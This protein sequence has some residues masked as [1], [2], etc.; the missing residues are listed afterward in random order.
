MLG[1]IEHLLEEHAA[2][3]RVLT[4]AQSALDPFE[5]ERLETALK[6]LE[7]IMDRVHHAKEEDALFPMLAECTDDFEPQTLRAMQQQHN[8]GRSYLRAAKALLEDAREGSA[9][10]LSALAETV[11]A[12]DRFTRTHMKQ[13]E[14]VLFPMIANVLSPERDEALLVH[15]RRVQGLLID[16]GDY[17]AYLDL[18]NQLDHEDRE[19]QTVITRPPDPEPIEPERSAPRATHVM[20][21]DQGHCVVRIP[22]LASPSA[23][24][25]NVY[26]VRDH[27]EAILLDPGGPASYPRI[28]DEVVI[29]LEDAR[30]EYV[31]LSHQDPDVGASVRGWL[32][33]TDAKV[34]SP[35]A[36]VRFIAHYGLD[37]IVESRAV[38]VPDEG[39]ILA[40]GSSD[41][42]VLPAHFLHSS[43]NVQLFD[44]RSKI[45]FSGDLGA[46]MTSASVV[47]DFDAHV[48]ELLAFHRRHMGGLDVVRAW[49]K[50]I[51]TLDVRTVAPQHG[52]VFEGEETVGRLLDWLESTPCGPELITPKIQLPTAR[53]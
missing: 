47:A 1:S 29:H 32:M 8:H 28:L 18:A 22:G 15:F 7:Y 5:P 49:V 11:R 25:T 12:Y 14:R 37:S 19:A 31:F 13:E 52:A 38:A 41:V 27:D 6:F 35:A 10:A 33:D 2:C 36:W 40:V 17:V 44:P 34:V 3:R 21:A 16:V 48:P 42:A 50:M 9:D 51:R 46:S 43:A 24:P 30:L 53:L 39:G 4:Q 20:F 26:L 23:M 45:L